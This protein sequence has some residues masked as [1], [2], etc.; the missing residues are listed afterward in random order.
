ML[1]SGIVLNGGSSSRMGSD[2]SE[3]MVQGKTIIEIIID[4]LTEANANEI[5]IIGGSKNYEHLSSKI[6]NCDD[7]YPQEGPLG[8]LITGLSNARYPIAMVIACDYLSVTAETILECLSNLSSKDMISPIY[9][10]K[11]QFLFSAVQVKALS[12]FQQ[13][14]NAGTR[15]MHEAIRGLQYGI[16]QSTFEEN[17]RSVNTPSELNE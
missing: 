14:F 2:K 5:L 16:Y 6:R 12:A 17:L 9:K 13:E 7:L 11:E 1:Y 3:I 8:G 4:A 10:G 15:S